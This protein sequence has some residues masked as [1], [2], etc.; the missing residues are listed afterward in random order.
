M[1]RLGGVDL[2]GSARLGPDR[3][4]NIPFSSSSG[5][6]MGRLQ[7]NCNRAEYIETKEQCE[8]AAVDMGL[9]QTVA[10]PVNTLDGVTAHGLQKG[11]SFFANQYLLWNEEGVDAGAF[12]R[13]EH[14]MWNFG[15]IF[16]AQ[17]VPQR[18]QESLIHLCKVPEAG[19]HPTTEPTPSPTPVPTS[20]PTP[21]PT[22]VPT[23]APSSQ[24]TSMPTPAPTEGPQFCKSWCSRSPSSWET[25]CAWSTGNCAGCSECEAL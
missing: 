3:L 6:F 15:S 13:H 10:H 16:C 8:R 11:C 4:T 20:V 24:P 5:D 21:F 1:R 14:C 23:P 19:L 12:G 18:S 7:A 9:W 17:W 2:A 25:K 22:S